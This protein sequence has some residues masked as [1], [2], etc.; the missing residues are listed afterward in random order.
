LGIVEKETKMKKVTQKVQPKVK[1]FKRKYVRPTLIAYGRL[2]EFTA[3]GSGAN[4]E[5][6]VN[7]GKM[8]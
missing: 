5:S 4:G 6:Q 2:S 1:V 7:P 3:S 8:A